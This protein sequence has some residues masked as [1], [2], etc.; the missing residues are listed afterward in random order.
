VITFTVEPTG[1]TGHVIEV[2]AQVGGGL[3]ATI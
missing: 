1:I 3:L 2:D